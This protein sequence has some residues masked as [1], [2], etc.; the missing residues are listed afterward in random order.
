MK[1]IIFIAPPAAGKGT[2]SEMLKDRYGYDHI[3]TGDLIRAE[4]KAGNKEL[5]EIISKGNLVSDEIIFAMLKK[6]LATISGP[7]ILDGFPRTINQCYLYTELVKEMGL[8]LGV[9]AYLTI[10]KEEAMRRVL[11]RLTCKNCKVCFNKFFKEKMPK[12]EGKCD[13]CGGELESRSDD[14]E[15]SFNHRFDVY[16]KEVENILDYY[17]SLGILK[18]IEVKDNPEDTFALVEKVIND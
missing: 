1:N 16:L 7:F 2:M 9:A 11:G 15:E 13:K 14:T 4:V 18:V 5:E 3:S 8:D 12:E 17:R 10:D 6:K